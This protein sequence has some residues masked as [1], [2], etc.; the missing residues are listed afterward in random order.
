MVFDVRRR[1]VPVRRRGRLSAATGL[2]ALFLVAISGPAQAAPPNSGS[3]R[4]YIGPAA[5][6]TQL[7]YGYAS[8]NANASPK[9]VLLTAEGYALASGSCETVY[10][11]WAIGPGEGSSHFDARAARD[12][13]S[14]GYDASNRWN[15][16]SAASRVNGVQKMGVCYGSNN[17]RGTCSDYSGTSTSSVP[18]N[19]SSETGITCISWVRR[20]ATGAL[21]SN[22]G[23]DPRSCSD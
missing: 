4:E 22:S 13:R 1:G 21:T 15:E 17:T 16:T 14:S 2:A 12:C 11:D 7:S 19:W 23:G 8:W 20:E 3:W 6:S 5:S 18:S 9:T 10:F